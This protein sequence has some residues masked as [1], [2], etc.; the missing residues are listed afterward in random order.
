MLEKLLYGVPS[1]ESEAEIIGHGGRKMIA[2]QDID[3]RCYGCLLFRLECEG[4]KPVDDDD[5]ACFMPDVDVVGEKTI[6]DLDLEYQ[7]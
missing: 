7:S 4:T 2:M 5:L 3:L 6:E 1:V